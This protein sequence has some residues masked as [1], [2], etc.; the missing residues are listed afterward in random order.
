MYKVLIVGHGYVGSA[1]AS[2]FSEN[3]KVIVDPKFND[4]KISDFKNYIFDA[5]FVSVDTP[6]AEGFKLLD[7][8]LEE[9]NENMLPGTPV[10]CKSTASPD[11]YD[12][13]SQKYSNIKVLHSP[14]YLNK[15]NPIKMF[16]EQTFFI[17]GGDQ[18]AAMAVADI[19]NTRLRHVKNV[20]I[21]DIRT[22]AMVKYAENAFLAL[23][24]SFFNEL[25]FAHKSQG[26]RSSFEEFAEM[27]GLDPRIGHSHTHVPGS[28]GKFGWE[29]HCLTK[30]LYELDKFSGSSL[31]RFIRELN[32]T[33]RNIEE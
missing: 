25:Y 18:D 24:V 7:N 8:V 21:T 17:L 3:E 9:L 11:F 1:V 4:N 23:K 15:T 14:E 27:V 31:V 5:V 30:D 6:K 28:D 33:H 26:C 16:Q 12:E 19:F 10:C 22:A 29:S 13:V 2:L 20:R 32:D